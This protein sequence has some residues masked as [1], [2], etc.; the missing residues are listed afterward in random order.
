MK[1][2]RECMRIGTIVMTSGVA[3]KVADNE[4]FAKQVQCFLELYLQKDWGNV[5]EE[6][7]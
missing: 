2:S 6:D 1:G 3:G 5:P 4:L 7:K